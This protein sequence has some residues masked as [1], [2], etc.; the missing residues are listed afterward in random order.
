LDYSFVYI[1][2]IVNG[3]FSGYSVYTVDSSFTCGFGDINDNDAVVEPTVPVG[4]G[5]IVDYLDVNKTGLS[6]YNWVQT[7]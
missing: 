2:H 6:T 4:V 3:A 1:P 7:Y 5:I